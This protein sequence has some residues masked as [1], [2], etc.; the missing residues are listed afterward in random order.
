MRAT[1]GCVAHAL[2]FHTLEDAIAA[3][4]EDHSLIAQATALCAACPLSAQCLY[5]AVVRHDVAGF[6][7]GT[8][9][10]QRRQIRAR[11]GARV[12]PEN[13][14]SLA[15]VAGG[16]R[17]VDGDEV[18]RLRRQYPAETLDQLALRLG[19]STSTVKR[20]LRSGRVSKSAERS[21][22]PRPRPTTSDVVDA[23]RTVAGYRAT[24]TA[25]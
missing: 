23:A 25:A 19:C 14:D 18:L 11:L 22:R 13:F 8:T 17:P 10:R 2:L 7:A 9:P 6:V 4:R 1:P 15:G 21:A 5:D 20:H 24:A 3:S 12:E 16:G